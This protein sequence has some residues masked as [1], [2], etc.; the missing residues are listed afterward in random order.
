MFLKVAHRLLHHW[1]LIHRPF[2]LVMFVILAVHVLVTTLLGY[3][4]IF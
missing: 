3:T 2:A 4:W 1:H